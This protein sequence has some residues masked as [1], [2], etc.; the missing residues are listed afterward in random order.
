MKRRD[1]PLISLVVFDPQTIA[2][3][4]TFEQPHQ[5]SIAI[6][7]VFINGVPVLKDG[8]HTERSQGE[9]YGAR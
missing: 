6:K 3:R 7:H 4:A 5:Y 9:R 2:D 8:E 1:L